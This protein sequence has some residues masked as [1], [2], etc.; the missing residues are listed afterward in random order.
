MSFMT[1]FGRSGQSIV[2]GVAFLMAGATFPTN[3]SNYLEEVMDI[4]EVLKVSTDS[5]H[6]MLYHV[7]Q[8]F[9][10]VFP[11]KKTEALLEILERDSAKKKKT[12]I[13]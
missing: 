2:T 6:R 7:P 13:F 12:Q 9:I 3:F 11:A 4:D 10:R 5:I 1:Q 8:K